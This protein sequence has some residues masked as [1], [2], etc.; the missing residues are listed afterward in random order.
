MGFA[1]HWQLLA[2]IFAE[3]M[4]NGVGEGI[5]LAMVGWALLRMSGR[6]N[7]STRFAV[8]F[9]M[10]VTIAALPFLGNTEFA[11]AG[12]AGASHFA[13]Q[14]PASYAVDIFVAWALI[15][16]AGLA[17]IGFGFWQL[18]RL[19]QSCDLIHSASL[20]QVLRNTLAQFGSSRPVT[21]CTSERVRTPA[22]IGFFKPAIVFPPWILQEFSP[23]EL[24][25][26]L[27]HELAHLRRWDDWTNLTQEIMRALFFFHPAFWWIGRGLALEREMACD[28][29]VL[30]SN[31]NPHAYAQC[32]VSMAEKSILRRGLEL[33]QAV[34][35]RVQQTTKRVMRILDAKRP[36]A[37]KVYKPALAMVTAFSAVC[38]IALTHAPRLIA[39]DDHGAR[40]SESA[41]RG[42]ATPALDSA[43]VVAKMI[44]AALHGQA[45]Y[46]VHGDIPSRTVSG[47]AV[48]LT[49]RSIYN[50]RAVVKNV[51][52]ARFAAPRINS[53]GRIDSPR[54][55]DANMLD[56]KMIDAKMLDATTPAVKTIDSNASAS[57]TFDDVS[58]PKA[59]LLLIQA[60][61]V[62]SDGHVWSISIMRLT[63]F[64]PVNRRIQK[65]I[66]PKT[67]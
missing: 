27:L 53:S 10:M 32:L 63:V 22:A 4:L 60:E 17:K 49:S 52:T 46:P 23:V 31:S 47:R 48:R 7:S 67:T 12:L 57:N 62:D 30:A 6:Q 66:I 61:A 5:L 59:M 28:D 24:N 51:A 44:P 9:S 56:A 20:D 11:G 34:V 35:G 55:L 54:M 37:T 39:F 38:L 43:D 13:F 2:Q 40:F 18:R 19:R 14:L 26:V 1:A 15:A 64:H 33:A 25:A 36:A 3:R 16:S 8:W 65:G 41:F 58:S 50:R 21:V 45:G 42:V 29:F